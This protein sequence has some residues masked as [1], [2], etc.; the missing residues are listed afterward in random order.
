[1]NQ[2]Q[3]DTSAA[4]AFPQAASANKSVFFHADGTPKS[5]REVY[6]WALKQTNLSGATAGSDFRPQSGANASWFSGA[7]L[8][9]EQSADALAALS[10][11]A[12]AMTP[13]VIDILG[14]LDLSTSARSRP[15]T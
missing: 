8:A 10:Q 5:V 2:S 14:S 15:N 12:F 7:M 1:M 6:D 9:D 3:P 13:G 11:S 4:S